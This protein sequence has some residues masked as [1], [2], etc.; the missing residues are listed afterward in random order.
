M[1]D[2]AS[3]TPEPWIADLFRRFEGQGF[4]DIAALVEHL[5]NMCGDTEETPFG[6]MGPC[7]LEV[8]HQEA[9]HVDH[10][11]QKWTGTRRE[12]L[13]C[14]AIAYKIR[15]ELVCCDI[16]EQIT[17]AGGGDSERIAQLIAQYKDAGEFHDLCYWGEA[18]AGIAEDFIPPYPSR[19]ADPVLWLT[20]ER[21]HLI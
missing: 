10:R 11:G 8:G 13:L 19:D 5:Q 3:A 2:D 14:E 18:A 4:N 9:W 1:S 20:L 12:V 17:T 15:A 6:A 16:Y 21:F 7:C